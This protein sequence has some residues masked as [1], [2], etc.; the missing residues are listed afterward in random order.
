MIRIRSIC[1]YFQ[2]VEKGILIVFCSLPSIIITVLMH[3]FCKICAQMFSLCK[4]KLEINDYFKFLQIASLLNP[5]CILY[6]HRPF[7]GSGSAES[8]FIFFLY[9]NTEL[10]QDRFKFSWIRMKPQKFSKK[11]LILIYSI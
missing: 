5:F 1:L 2:L 10:R 4:R 9:L 7:W 11:K 8:V 6:S 3:I